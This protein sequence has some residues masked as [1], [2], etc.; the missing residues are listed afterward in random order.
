MIERDCEV[1][2]ESAFPEQTNAN[3]P[4][5]LRET[6]ICMRDDALAKIDN[7][8]RGMGLQNQR[9]VLFRNFNNDRTLLPL[10]SRLLY[11]ADG[12]RPI[13]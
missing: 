2:E 13:G 5:S 4:Q 1:I 3:R 10:L 9:Q 11:Y 8:A 12:V 6:R 7:V